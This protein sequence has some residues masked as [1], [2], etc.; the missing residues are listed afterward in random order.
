MLSADKCCLS[1]GNS[2]SHVP[3]QC[4]VRVLPCATYSYPFA[5]MYTVERDGQLDF[6]G[7]PAFKGM[8]ANEIDESAIRHKMLGTHAEIAKTFPMYSAAAKKPSRMAI[9]A[10]LRDHRSRPVPF[11]DLPMPLPVHFLTFRAAVPYHSTAT[12]RFERLRAIG[13]RRRVEA[14]KS[15]RAV[16]I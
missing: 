3:S 15:F 13:R 2:E 9:V 12:T 14:F 8:A 10:F 16:D 4:T 6:D 5:S 11:A 7:S 1:F